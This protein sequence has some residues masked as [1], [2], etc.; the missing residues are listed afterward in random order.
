MNISLKSFLGKVLCALSVVFLCSPPIATAQ[1]PGVSTAPKKPIECDG[2]FK[3]GGKPNEEK[4]KQILAAHT[5]WVDSIGTDGKQANLC[6]ADLREAQLPE[7]SLVRRTSPG[8]PSP[9]RTS[10]GRP[11]PGRPSPGRTSP[12]RPSPGRT[13]PGRTSS[14][15]TSPWRISPGRISP[16]RISPG[17]T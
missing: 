15:R 17:L 8:R 1:E 5:Q 9:G 14:R 7:V 6:E 13:S 16:G 12:G 2:L 3:G 4:L 10:P 11:S